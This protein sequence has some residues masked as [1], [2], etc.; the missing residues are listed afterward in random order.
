MVD[1]G[2]QAVSV[3]AYATRAGMVFLV[4]GLLFQILLYVTKF[5]NVFFPGDLWNNYSYMFWGSMVY[6]ISTTM[7]LAIACMF[8]QVLYNVI[9]V[10]C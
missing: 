8:L 5:T 4:F 3:I 2:W 9:F 7:W 1:L 6:V 10:R